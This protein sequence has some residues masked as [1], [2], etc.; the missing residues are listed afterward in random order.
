MVDSLVKAGYERHVL[1]D[2]ENYWAGF[3]AADKMAP[4]GLPFFV[5]TTGLE[6]RFS[7]MRPYTGR[8]VHWYT[9]APADSVSRWVQSAWLYSADSIE[10][11][12]GVSRGTGTYFEHRRVS[13]GSRAYGDLKVDTAVLRFRIYADGAYR[14]DG[15]YVLAAI[16]AL[17]KVTGKRLEEGDGGWLFWLSAKPVAGAAGYAHIWKY[18]EGKEVAVDTWM[19]DVRLMKE[20]VGEE[21]SGTPVWRD[22]YGRGI[23]ARD[24]KVF[25]FYSRLD[26]NWGDLV[27][28]RR[29]PILLAGLMVDDTV[30]AGRDRR[31]LDLRQVEP[32]KLGVTGERAV[33]GGMQGTDWRPGI[34]VIVFLLF[35]LE[36]VIAFKNGTGKA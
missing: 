35:F 4:A 30:I 33:T 25:S 1:A 6:S 34:W 36:R 9:Y 11:V 18:A 17:R 12:E 14:A 31:M 8:D 20:I 16:K 13:A 19:G 5:F 10:V 32:V 28:S 3:R 7:G 29:W 2:S 15:R 27:W 21:G 26:V 24:G 23:L 22:G